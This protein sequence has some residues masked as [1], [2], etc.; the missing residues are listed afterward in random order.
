M[1]QIWMCHCDNF[2]SWRCEKLKLEWKMSCNRNRHIL[3]SLCNSK[4]L[5]TKGS[6]LLLYFNFQIKLKLCWPFHM[7]ERRH[8][9]VWGWHKHCA[10]CPGGGTRVIC[11][12]AKGW[13]SEMCVLHAL[14]KGEAGVKKKVKEG[15][16]SVAF[17]D[18]VEWDIA[19][20]R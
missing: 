5:K 12:F 3:R 8:G 15:L 2:T 1:S 18:R 10:H 19:I 13:F 11:D 4:S 17:S 9:A 20:Q 6:T 7:F 16:I 14:I